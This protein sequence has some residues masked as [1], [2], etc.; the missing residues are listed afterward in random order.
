MLLHNGKS[1]QGRSSQGIAGTIFIEFLAQ[2]PDVLK[3]AILD[4]QHSAE[5][6]QTA[7]LHCLYVGS[8]R[9]GSRGEHDPDVLQSALR[10][11]RLRT[12]RAYHLPLCEPPST[13]STSPVT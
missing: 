2:A 8:K 11:S 7:C 6:E 1:I 4:R 5:E 13:C 9:M 3:L 12:A 10:A